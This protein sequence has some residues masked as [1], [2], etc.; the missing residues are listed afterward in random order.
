MHEPH[1]FIL[2]CHEKQSNLCS[3]LYIIYISY[4]FAHVSIGAHGLEENLYFLTFTCLDM[5]VYLCD[6]FRTCDLYLLP[7]PPSLLPPSHCQIRCLQAS[8][9]GK[10]SLPERSIALTQQLRLSL[11]IHGCRTLDLLGSDFFLV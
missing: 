1:Q 11:R 4:I 7:P 10:K 5:C 8:A 6:Q 9:K 3:R 2:F